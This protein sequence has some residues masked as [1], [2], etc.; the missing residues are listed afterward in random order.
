MSKPN[1]Q[2][3]MISTEKSEC[4]TEL[5]SDFSKKYMEAGNKAVFWNELRTND[6]MCK[7]YIDYVE[8]LECNHSYQ[9]DNPILQTDS[10]KG[11]QFNMFNDVKPDKNGDK[12][13]LVD[14]YAFIEPRKGARD[15]Y[16]VVAGTQRIANT[17]AT[18]RLTEKH[19][20]EAIWFYSRHFSTPTHS[21]KYHFNPLPW[22]KVVFEYNGCL[23][24]KL[25]AIPDGTIIPIAVPICTLEST[26]EDCA[27][28][29][30]H[31][32]GLVQK[33]YWYPSTV[34]TNGLGFS[35]VIKDALK[36]TASPEVMNGWLPFAIQ[37]FGYRGCTSEDAAIIGGGAA[38]YVTMGSDTIPAIVDT[39]INSKTLNEM[40]GYSVAA[41]EHNQAFS[42]GRDGE[43]DFI[44][45][46]LEVYP[47]GILSVVADTFDLRK[48]VE[49][50]TSGKLRDLIMTRDGTYVIRPDSQLLNDD[51]SEMSP[52]ETI[53]T[54][55]SIMGKNLEQF[56]TVNNR[57]FKVLPKQYKVI[58]GDGL[59]IPKIKDILDYMVRDGWCATNIIFGIGGNLLQ[60]INRDTERFA[61]KSSQQVFEITNI[62]GSVRK[63]VRNVGKETPG[64]ESKR[65]KFHVGCIDGTIQ[66]NDINDPKVIGIPN[67]LVHYC[68]NGNICN[69]FDNI[70][71]IRD[72]VNQYRELYGI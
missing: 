32:E 53:S 57:G 27:Q 25:S 61:M 37:D 64:K 43:F 4:K 52:A 67:M 23:P 3:N 54:I 48:N 30:S 65:G 33:A 17:L 62:D 36:T 1:Y 8:S 44:E 31:F 26:D 34:A 66:C 2:Y 42:R 6:P 13:R 22:L 39:M 72:R 69:S 7:E 63:E 58:Y 10:Y 29:V 45:N 46:L 60:N 51:G 40:A 21:G 50:V 28:L 68:I 59:N 70:N 15:P 11:S 9:Q 16:I 41:C 19:I 12:Q 14:M 49:T 56:I 5:V 18:I 20:M 35:K 47:N 71:T 24:L 38:L 55:F